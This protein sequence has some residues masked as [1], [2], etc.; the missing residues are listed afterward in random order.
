MTWIQK[1]LSAGG[2]YKRLQDEP[3]TQIFAF[4]Y[5]YVTLLYRFC[6]WRK[7]KQYNLEV[8]PYSTNRVIEAVFDESLFYT[9]LVASVSTRITIADSGPRWPH[10]PAA[11]REQKVVIPLVFPY[12]RA[13]PASDP[14]GGSSLHRNHNSRLVLRDKYVAPKP[15]FLWF[16]A[17]RKA[18][19]K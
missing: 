7:R 17:E 3:I 5:M 16:P 10:T 11:T 15:V 12:C 8:E 6:G 2:Y 4:G 1:L 19:Q 14:T 13:S 18:L 9:G